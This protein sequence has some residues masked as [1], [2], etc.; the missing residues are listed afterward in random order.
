LGLLP[1]WRPGAD[2][3]YPH[4]L[5]GHGSGCLAALNPSPLQVFNVILSGAKDFNQY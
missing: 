1:E 3:D 4:H 5:G 2:F